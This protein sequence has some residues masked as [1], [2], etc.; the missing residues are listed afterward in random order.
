M[1]ISL[2]FVGAY[3]LG[4]QFVAV[5]QQVETDRQLSAKDLK[6]HDHKLVTEEGKRFIVGS[7]KNA[8]AKQRYRAADITFAVL[9]KEGN[10]LDSA[11]DATDAELTPGGTWDFRA[12][13]E[14]DQA[15]TY[16]FKEVAGIKVDAAWDSMTPEQ[17]EAQKRLIREGK[18]RVKKV[19]DDAKAHAKQHK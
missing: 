18:E 13:V 5:V 4:R 7:V 16:K 12:E 1:A 9:D 3:F 19:V 10:D 14:D 2:F 11:T 17:K 15:A 8:S 6:V